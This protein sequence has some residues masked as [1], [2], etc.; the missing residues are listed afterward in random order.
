MKK[1]LMLGTSYGS[2]EMIRYAKKKGAY[3]IVTDYLEPEKSPAKY[4]ADEYWMINTSE[5]DFLEEKCRKEQINAIVCGVSE[6]NL[7]ICMKLCNRL[8]LPCYCNEVA[9]SYS[10]DKEKFKSLCKRLGAQVA[11]DYF[12]SDALTREELEKVIFPV[13]V[14]PVDMSGNR[15]ISFCHN[16]EELVEAYRYAKSVSKSDKIIVERMLHGKE[17]YAYYAMAEGRISLVALNA[18]HSQ[19]GE[20]RNCYSITTTVSDNVE[21]Y[22]EEMNPYV[23]KILEE[24]GCKEGIGWVQFMLDEDGKFYILEMGYRLDGDMMFIPYR[25]VR[26]FDSVEWLVVFAFGQKK[27]ANE[28]PEDQTH[29]F[30]KCGVGY[31]LWTNKSGIIAEIQGLDEVA[32][33]PEIQLVESLAR[34]GDPI[35]I[36]RSLGNI[37]FTADNC[38]EMCRVI[39]KINETIRIL[40][41][42]GE[43]VVIH[44]DNFDYLKEIYQKGLSE[45]D[46][47]GVRL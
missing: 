24:A 33:W 18:M 25:E 44:Y 36:H 45:R 7:E 16:V 3:T 1:M 32:E 20:P 34:I 41:T 22:I 30:V 28:L 19:P 27:R 11:T 47:F 6:F 37:M 15:G 8:N 10:R 21:R 26:G 35:T 38:D 2:I 12:L 4:E 14:K 46:A 31:M 17:W 13:V 43:N 23:I 9:W 29:A 39:K 5:L 40:N 42:E